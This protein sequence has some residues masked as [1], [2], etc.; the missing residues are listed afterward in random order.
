LI[1]EAQ[2]TTGM[3]SV[4]NFERFCKSAKIN[5]FNNLNCRFVI[6]ILIVLLIWSHLMTVIL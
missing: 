4:H 5:D 6:L 1:F 2:F 3:C